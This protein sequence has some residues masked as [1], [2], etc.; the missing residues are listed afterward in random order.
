M[1]VLAFV[2]LIPPVVERFMVSAGLSVVGANRI[3]A[4]GLIFTG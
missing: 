1:A 2:L 4:I 3:I